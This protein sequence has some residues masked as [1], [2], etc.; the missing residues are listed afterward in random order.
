MNGIRESACIFQKS[1]VSHQL[2]IPIFILKRTL[3]EKM[4]KEPVMMAITQEVDFL[5]H[6]RE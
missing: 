2:Q 5:I 4:S 6:P 1:R 3:Q